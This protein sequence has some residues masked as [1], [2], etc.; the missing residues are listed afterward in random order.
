M[1]TVPQPEF[2][3]NA[4]RTDAEL[5]LLRHGRFW[6]PAPL[7]PE[8]P[9]GLPGNCYADAVM[10]ALYDESVTYVEGIGWRGDETWIDSDGVELA[11]AWTDADGV[12]H[13][14]W[15]PHAWTV[16]WAGVVTDATWDEPQRCSYFGVPVPLPVAL[17][18]LA[19]PGRFGVFDHARRID[20]ELIGAITEELEKWRT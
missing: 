3:P 9:R 20:P 11:A 15:S 6:T 8:V 19:Q 5:F 13:Q 1:I 14:V 18:R 12:E 10:R 17:H 4:D 16:D 7:P 2:S